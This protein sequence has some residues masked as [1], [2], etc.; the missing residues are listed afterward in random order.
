MAK[1]NK[2]NLTP[3]TENKKTPWELAEEARK[4]LEKLAPNTVEY[5]KQRAD[6]DEMLTNLH[7][8]NQIPGDFDYNKHM[9]ES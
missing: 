5:Y 6:Y 1:K 9:R 8:T 7:N 2:K 4:E 3:P